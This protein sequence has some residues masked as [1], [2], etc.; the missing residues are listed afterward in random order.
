[1]IF[2]VKNTA[3]KGRSIVI[4]DVRGAEIA[5]VK[6]YNSKTRVAKLY[7]LAKAKPGDKARHF[8][9]KRNKRCLA[10]LGMLA[11]IITVKLPG[12]YAVYQ[13]KRY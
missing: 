7:L 2:T 12:S 4:Y 3:Q 5:G 10:G 13:G 1:M 11:V 8:L 6:E 9:M